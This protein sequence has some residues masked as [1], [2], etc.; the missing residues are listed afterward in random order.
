MTL[1]SKVTLNEGGSVDAVNGQPLP[2]ITPPVKVGYIFEGYYDG[3]NGTGTKYYNADGSGARVWDKSGDVTL[4]AK[5]VEGSDIFGTK[6]VF[7]RNIKIADGRYKVHLFAGINSLKYK[8]VGFEVSINGETRTLST[9][10]VFRTVKATNDTVTPEKLGA[11]C[12]SI[13]GHTI[14]LGE[15]MKDA[16]I[17]YRPYA[18][19]KNGNTFYGKTVTINGVYT[20]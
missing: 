20:K 8:Q 1:A 5:W 10:F 16:V 9:K 7:M 2:R 19:D 18:V 4:Y 11:K 15:D 17:T 6:G 3:A 14:Q 13:F 12:T